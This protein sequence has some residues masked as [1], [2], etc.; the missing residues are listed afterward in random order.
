MNTQQP[1]FFYSINRF[2]DQASIS[3]SFFYKLCKAG[4]GPELYREKNGK[5]VFIPK[6]S[7]KEWFEENY[8]DLDH[9]NLHG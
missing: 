6:Q 4:K 5:K 7:A 3:R 9:Y 8:M 1:E 2:C